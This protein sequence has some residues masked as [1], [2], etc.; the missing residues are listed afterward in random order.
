MSTTILVCAVC[1][2]AVASAVRAVLAVLD[3]QPARDA[4]T[5]ALVMQRAYMRMMEAMTNQPH[6]TTAAP[7]LSSMTPEWCVRT[8]HT[9]NPGAS[10]NNI[11]VPSLYLVDFARAVVRYMEGE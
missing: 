3:Y 6:R 10:S 8:F 11:R 9:V 1:V 5:Q 2:M 4:R 7:L